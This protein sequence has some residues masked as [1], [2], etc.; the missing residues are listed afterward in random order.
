MLLFFDL[1]AGIGGFRL[2]LEKVGNKC[3]GFCEIDRFA[4]QTYT[5]NFDTTK[6]AEWHDITTVG[7]DTIREL[8]RVDILTAG[9][10]C[11]AF[12]IA[13]KREGFQDT[14]GT[15]FFEIVRFARILKPKYLLLENVRG[16]LSHDN[17]NTFETILHTLGELGY[18]VEWQ[19]LNSKN[20]GVPQHR[21]RV[22]I[23]GHLGGEPRR[24]VFP[25]TRQSKQ[26]IKQIGNIIDTE[27]FGGNPQRGRVY[28]PD[29]LCPSLNTMQGGGLEPK[30]MMID[31]SFS[32]QFG[33][34]A[35]YEGYSPT[36]R[37]SGASSLKVAIPVLTPEREN[38]RQNGRRFKEDGDPMFT[39]TSQDRHGVA[40]SHG[41]LIPRDIAMTIDANYAKGF[42]NRG[43]RTGV[44]ETATKDIQIRMLTPLECFRLQ[45]FPD[46]HHDNAKAV[47]VSDSLLYKL[48]G[49]AIT[50]NVVYDI[51]KTLADIEKG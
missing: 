9:F 25:I 8:G 31:D 16:L 51:A 2:A 7:D 30:I 35:V 46:S 6:E 32:K 33:G 19:I 48:A 3:V 18:W 39:I 45:G 10:P 38:K 13:G 28:S 49:N 26:T 11:Q 42:D 23:I 24:K 34:T 4:R 21:E 20:F 44:A 1:F 37:A 14:R 41:E 5:A 12:S 36:L 40:V 43:G 27:S 15:L 22:F 50:V 29:G 47:G 17:G